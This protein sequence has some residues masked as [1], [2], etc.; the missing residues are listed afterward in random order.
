MKERERKGEK[1]NEKAR[2]RKRKR[3]IEDEELQP[4][5]C[6]HSHCSR[7]HDKNKISK[8]SNFII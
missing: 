5:I 4:T 2:K 7:S 8:V 1:E 3:N 6:R